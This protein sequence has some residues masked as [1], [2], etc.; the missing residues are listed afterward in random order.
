MTRS[1]ELITDCYCVSLLVP[2]ALHIIE[3]EVVSFIIGFEH[4]ARCTHEVDSMSVNIITQLINKLLLKVDAV[5]I[6]V[7]LKLVTPISPFFLA[8][9]KSHVSKTI[10]NHDFHRLFINE[11]I[12][13]QSLNTSMQ[14]REI[15]RFEI[16]Y[17]C[18]SVSLLFSNMIK[19]AIDGF[20]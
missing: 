3:S 6:E 15:I 11:D 4:G 19:K 2:R 20:Y 8:A 17:L 12:G 18:V 7:F 1:K 16:F 9:R 10:R 14:I 13:L 5:F